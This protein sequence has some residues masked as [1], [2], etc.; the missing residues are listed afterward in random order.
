MKGERGGTYLGTE[1]ACLQKA[2]SREV[3]HEKPVES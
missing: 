2:S 3:P 1:E